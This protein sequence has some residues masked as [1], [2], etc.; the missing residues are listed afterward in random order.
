MSKLWVVEMWNE[1]M[2]RFEPTVGVGLNRDSGRIALKQ[3]RVNN[4]GDTFRLMQYSRKP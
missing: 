1:E 4:P 2:E 3:W